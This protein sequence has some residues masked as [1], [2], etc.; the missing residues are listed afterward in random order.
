M[1]PAAV[2]EVG[3]EAPLP[4]VD[5]GLRAAVVVAAAVDDWAP[6]PELG[7]DMTAMCADDRPN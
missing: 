2:D 5:P 7:L 4:P 1:L 3:V 6:A